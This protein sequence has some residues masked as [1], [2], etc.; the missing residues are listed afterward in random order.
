M[1][2][3]CLQPSV[4]LIGGEVNSIPELFVAKPYQG[5]YNRDSILSCQLGRNIGSAVGNYVNCHCHSFPGKVLEVDWIILTLINAWFGSS[6][7][8][9]IPGCCSMNRSNSTPRLSPTIS[10]A[11]PTSVTATALLKERSAAGRVSMSKLTLGFRIRLVYFRLWRSVMNSSSLWSWSIMNT[12]RLQCGWSALD[13]AST[14]SFC[15]AKGVRILF[16]IIKSVPF[17]A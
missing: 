15:P 8:R 5:R 10:S 1:V 7:N 17:R 14:A 12:I 4:K 13:V 9:R 3:R 6:A 11:S 2:R 16:F